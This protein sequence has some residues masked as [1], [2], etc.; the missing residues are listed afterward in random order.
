MPSKKCPKCRQVIKAGDFEQHR[1]S[2]VRETRERKGSTRAWRN[3]RTLILARDGGL[4][5]VCRAPAVEIHH[6]NGDSTD[7]RPDNLAS[8]CF[9]HNPRGTQR[10]R[11][12]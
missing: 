4:C 3:L 11:G 5:V 9:E 8:V 7:D 12:F 10:A 2:H 1:L 6:R